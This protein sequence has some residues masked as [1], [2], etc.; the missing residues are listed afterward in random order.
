MEMSE[1][2]N[3]NGN[4]GPLTLL[5][6]ILSLF[7]I[8]LIVFTVVETIN[9]IKAGKYIGQEIESLKT[10]TVSGTG[11]IYAK[12]D[13]SIV[14]FSVITDATTVAKAMDDNTAKMNAIIDFMKQQGIEDKDLKTINFNISPLYEFYKAGTCIP[15]CPTGKRVLTG[16]E[17]TQSLQVKIR[18]MAKIGDIIQGGTDKGANQVG[19][20]QFTIDKEDELKKQAREQAI[21]EAKTKAGELASQLGV[22]LTRIVNFNESGIFPYYSAMKEAAPAGM[23]G[24]GTPPQI[25]TGEN[26]IEVTVNITYQ[27]D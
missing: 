18:D 4:K 23:G 19:D 22:K 12:P 8:A 13:L 5:G 3:V 25:E 17:V 16:Y 1:I 14:D 20:L 6:M 15:P 10:I 26:K 24:G 9:K 2:K 7:L 21:A 11:D 27:I